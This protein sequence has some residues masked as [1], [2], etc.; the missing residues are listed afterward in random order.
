MTHTRK[1]VWIERFSNP[2]VNHYQFRVVADFC[3]PSAPRAMQLSHAVNVAA[4]YARHYGAV[5]DGVHYVD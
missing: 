4:A 5:Y 3:V 1:T 2:N